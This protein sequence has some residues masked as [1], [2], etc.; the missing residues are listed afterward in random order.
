MD[1]CYC[2]RYRHFFRWAP[3][4]RAQVR[5]EVF[6]S[7][8]RFL[9]CSLWTTEKPSWNSYCLDYV[10]FTVQVSTPRCV[11]FCKLLVKRSAVG[12]HSEKA[13]R[14]SWV[15]S[16]YVL[17]VLCVFQKNKNWW[18]EMKFWFALSSQNSTP[19]EIIAPMFQLLFPII[20]TV[21]SSWTRSKE[22]WIELQKIYPLPP[23]QSN[24]PYKQHAYSQWPLR[25]RHAFTKSIQIQ[26]VVHNYITVSVQR[27]SLEPY[28][29]WFWTW[30]KHSAPS[31]L[32]FKD[33]K[34]IVEVFAFL[35]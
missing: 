20:Y 5:D 22:S 6:D 11:A 7:I 24:T 26:D 31:F 21:N 18:M 2:R 16:V 4:R 13:R 15:W 32:R 1:R 27:K 29:L 8:H 25:Q 35:S 12:K 17:L 3:F 14:Y 33:G 23:M 28:Y 10:L 34:W 30:N 9:R 19:P